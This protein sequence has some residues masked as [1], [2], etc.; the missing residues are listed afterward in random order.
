[1]IRLSSAV[2]VKNILAEF[3]EQQASETALQPEERF[4]NYVLQEKIGEGAFGTV[5]KA[6]QTKPLKREVALKILKAGMDTEEILTRFEQERQVLAVMNHPHVNRVFDAGMTEQERPY[7]VMELVPDGVPLTDYCRA[8]NLNLA[9]RL[10]LFCAVCSG[11]QHAHEKGIIHRDLKPSN[12]LVPKDEEG[13]V[14]IIDFG[15]AKPGAVAGRWR[16]G[17]SKRRLQPGRNSL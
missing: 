7:F 12:L 16:G 2:K 4:G 10:A 11:V 15:I 13:S 9:Q 17:Y 1:M 8:Q 6:T 5:W 3:Y 14:K